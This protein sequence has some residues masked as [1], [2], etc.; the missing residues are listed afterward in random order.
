MMPTQIYLLGGI[1]SVDVSAVLDTS[2]DV[3]AV[4]EVMSRDTNL[5][6]KKIPIPAAESI[7]NYLATPK[8]F[9]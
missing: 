4:L 1:A 8:I 2:V 3:S 7:P 9:I 6:D 5:K